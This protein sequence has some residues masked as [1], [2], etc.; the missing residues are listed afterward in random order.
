LFRDNF[1]LFA[2]N[3][4]LHNAIEIAVC[5]NSLVEVSSPWKLAKD[6]SEE[7]RRTLDAVL[8]TLAESLRIIAILISPVLPRAAH[9]IFDQLNWKMELSGKEERFSLADAEWGRL[10]DGHVVGK[11]VPLFR[12]IE[13]RKDV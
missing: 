2:P 3:Y 13:I 4:A 10:P 7:S 11:P 6:T 9:G 1:D 12:R 8:Y 5:G